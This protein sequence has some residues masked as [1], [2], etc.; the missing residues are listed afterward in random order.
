MST[1]TQTVVSD[2]PE[3]QQKWY[4]NLQGTG[5]LQRTKGALEDQR[6][7]AAQATGD[8]NAWA[9]LR[10]FA[11]TMRQ[12]VRPWISG[13]QASLESSVGGW[14]DP[15]Q[16][17][18]DFFGLGA[19]GIGSGSEALA[20]SF[21][22]AAQFPGAYAQLGAAGGIANL[23]QG[24]MQGAL[25]TAGAGIT[26]A[27]DYLTQQNIML[28]E[29]PA[30]VRDQLTGAATRFENT[31]LDLSDTAL[32]DAGTSR[33]QVQ[34][35]LRQAGGD[36][37]RALQALQAQGVQ[38]DR[39]PV[40][41][42]NR[43]MQA[44]QSQAA[45]MRNLDTQALRQAGVTQNQLQ[46]ALRQ[47]G[48]D[49]NRALQALQAQGVQ[50]DRL[51]VDARNRLTQAAQAQT[52]QL[53]DLDN[54]ALGQAGIT[55]NQLQDALRQAGG[56]T[57]RALQSLQAQGV[58]LD[59][60][61]VDARNRLMQA[62]QSQAARLQGLD[63]RTFGQ[64]DV[65]Q[66][67]A[68]EAIARGRGIAGS[69]ADRL[70][71]AGGMY[72][73]SMAQGFMDPFRRDV[74]EAQ[75]REM[76][77]LADIQ[78]Q[79]I[80]AQ[81]VGAGAFGGSREAVQ[82]AELTRNLIEQQSRLS[83]ELMS[84]GYSEAQANSMAAFEAAQQRQLQGA[85]GAGQIGLSAE[86]LAAQ[87]GLQGGQLGIQ[88]IQQAMQNAQFLAQQGLSAE[89][90]AAQTGL[91]AQQIQQA[92]IMGG[93]QLGQSMAQLGAQTQ[94][95]GGQMG[96]Q[97]LQ[98]AMQNAQFLAQQGLSAEQIAA[99]TG[100][101]AQQIQQAGI[102][103][104]GQLGQSMGQLGTQ[105]QLAGGQMGMQALQ[106]AMQNAQFL[107]QQGLSAE[108]IAAQTGLSAQ[109]IQ[110]AGIMGGGQL[111]QSMGQLGIQGAATGGQFGQ[112]GVQQAMQAAQFLAQ[113]GLSAEQIASQTG[114]SAAQIEQAGAN[115]YGQFGLSLG[116]LGMQ[117]AQ[118]TGQ[119]AD[120]MRQL[121]L[122]QGALGAQEAEIF[123][124]G[125]LGFG[126][127][128]EQ[129][130]MLGG[131]QLQAADVFS[132]LGGR[133]IN[134]Q[135]G[136]GEYHRGVAQQGFDTTFDNQMR[137][138]SMPVQTLQWE[139]DILRGVPSGQ[140]TMTQFSHPTQGWGTQAAAA[141]ITALGMLGGSGGG[142]G[143]GSS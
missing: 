5:I 108:Q 22:A 130:G 59:R 134:R 51:P 6:A 92:G 13:A 125:G 132:T 9:P 109:Q 52:T 29:M 20:R 15:L 133:D 101:S 19:Q 33:N 106:Q 50:L 41:A 58:Q 122:G 42:R 111:G 137:Q 78:R 75:Q 47:A 88:G 62:A 141:G 120:L 21:G 85:S 131:R 37:T 91:S 124:Q 139:A 45:Q 79:D 27:Q 32:A 93:G 14:A 28:R 135:L 10:G 121:A 142:F 53:R 11:D 113:Q 95:A 39:L 116:Q 24:Q 98:Q 61:P 117:G 44:A 57:T 100:L 64:T 94:L 70:L 71:G 76:Q 102:M 4:E 138:W 43:L 97:A 127:L 86:Q 80:R 54:Q 17:A 114:L 128:G 87:T 35:A 126:A 38:L 16:S 56:D 46:D 67:Q 104:G 49:T 30:S 8:P 7:F 60:L 69:A 140:T 118:L 36:T 65:A 48:G 34:D 68:Q 3:W 1:S 72:D 84:Q 115:M 119:Q 31:L 105:A 136:M 25:G 82:Q 74:V 81:A 66:Q 103:G 143:F 2:L 83:A 110:Q 96:M 12:D 123:R 26:G 77:R 73:P 40:D 18:Q 23:M 63:Q 55:Q 129:L 90:I 89:Q 107:A 99:Q 112:Q